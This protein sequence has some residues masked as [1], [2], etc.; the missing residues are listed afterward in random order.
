ESNGVLVFTK[1][2]AG[3]GAA[4]NYGI[5]RAK[6]ELVAT[7]DADSYLKPDTL[8][9]ILPL[10]DGG[11]VMAVTPAVKIKVG[12]GILKE[13]QRV[14]YLV[15][16]FSRKVLSYID[17]VPVTPGPFS[18]FRKNVFSI[19]GGFDEHNLVE[20]QEIALRIQSHNFKIRSSIDAEVITEPPVGLKDLILQ[21]V[22]WQRGGIRNYWKYRRLVS[23]TYGDFGM[24]FIPMNFVALIAFFLLFGIMIW[25]VLTAPYYARYIWVDSFSM[26]VDLL[27]VVAIFVIVSSILFTLVVVS[28]FKEEKV[29]LRYIIGF[30]FFYW[31]LMIC[32]NLLTLWKEIR[33][34]SFS[35]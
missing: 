22:R 2:N 11:D 34:E 7:M 31:Y 17:A 28:A 14:E 18:I 15:I 20:D 21:R 5:A 24:F 3:K 9:N 13:L 26:G 1:K 23:P 33:R 6:G 30:S 4:L 16:L 35:W 32:Y 8:R 19:V 10:F 12:G 25:S 29:K 27:S